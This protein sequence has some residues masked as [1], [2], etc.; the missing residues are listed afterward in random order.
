MG[1]H[2]SQPSEGVIMDVLEI[3]VPLNELPRTLYKLGFP[4]DVVIAVAIMALEA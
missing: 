3:N 4:L 2:L 1:P